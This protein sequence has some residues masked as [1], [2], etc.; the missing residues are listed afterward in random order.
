MATKAL[1]KE[2]SFLLCAKDE[3][4]GEQLTVRVRADRIDAGRAEELLES[5][6]SEF[7]SEPEESGLPEE[8]LGGIAGV[9]VLDVDTCSSG[10]KNFKQ[11]LWKGIS[12]LTGLDEEEKRD[13]R[14]LAKD[15]E[16]GQLERQLANKKARV[17]D[18]LPVPVP[19]AGAAARALSERDNH[20]AAAADEQGHDSLVTEK[21]AKDLDGEYDS[22]TAGLETIVLGYTR[23]LSKLTVA[24]LQSYCKAY[25]INLHVTKKEDSR[26]IFTK[27]YYTSF[28]TAPEAVEHF[29][30]SNGQPLVAG[31]E[32][33]QTLPA[34]RRWWPYMEK[35]GVKF[36][37][38]QIT[39]QTSGIQLQSVFRANQGVTPPVTLSGS[40]DVI[41]SGR[42]RGDD[43][44][45]LRPA[46][47]DDE[48]HRTPR[49]DG[50]LTNWKTALTKE[51]LRLALE[52]SP[53]VIEA[54]PSD[55]ALAAAQLFSGTMCA[56]AFASGPVIMVRTDFFREYDICAPE[57]RHLTLYRDLP[58]NVALPFIIKWLKTPKHLLPHRCAAGRLFICGALIALEPKQRRRH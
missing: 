36:Y 11:W 7:Y 3:V 53:A 20:S 32:V 35:H 12:S 54:K 34:L 23:A 29:E 44:E 1:P 14:R 17:S 8:A 13:L 10:L 42:R 19:E 56:N 46:I 31:K 16:M 26:H 5:E 27:R 55:S 58:A 41:L 47:F 30:V 18:V 51:E 39:S 57:D 22:Y 15:L 21:I 38:P 2:G 52:E 45:W 48:G 33:E 6:Y 9:V 40:P 25:N 28:V 24:E 43:G 50:T 4:T 37:E 49:E